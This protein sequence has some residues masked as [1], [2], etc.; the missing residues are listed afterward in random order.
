MVDKTDITLWLNV[1]FSFMTVKPAVCD[2]VQFHENVS[3]GRTCR[4]I[5]GLKKFPLSSHWFESISM[6]NKTIRM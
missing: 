1:A 5:T 4:G 6:G 3:I 2:L